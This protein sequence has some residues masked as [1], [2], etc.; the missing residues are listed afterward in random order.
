[1]VEYE[2]D[3]IVQQY[4]TDYIRGSLKQNNEL[5]S[6][7]EKYAKEND[8]P[9]VQPETAKF[10]ETFLMANKPLKILEVGC[11]IGYSAIIMA[12]AS[13]ESEITTLEF[14]ENIVDVAREN[15]KKAGLSSRIKVVYADA[16]DYI[17]YMDCDDYF[18]LVF[19]DGPKAHYINMLDD[20]MR[21]LKK[22]GILMCDN[23]LYKGMTADDSLLIKRK[24]T[25]VKRLRKLIDELTTRDDMETSIL[26]VGDGMTVSVKKY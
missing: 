9:I 20:C 15:I 18:D 23:I 12:S 10:I 26:T 17:P 16:R 8:V 5:L 14:D 19:L 7:M 4:V 13:P 3:G 2:K 21:L 25:I 6:A 22:G 24:I 11:A 1:M